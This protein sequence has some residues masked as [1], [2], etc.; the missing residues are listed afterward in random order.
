MKAKLG[1]TRRALVLGVLFI[2][3]AGAALAP[4][5]AKARNFIGVDVGPLSVGIGANE[6]DYYVAPAPAPATTYVAPAPST[7]Y[8]EPAPQTS[9]APPPATYQ[10]P[11]PT[12][13]RPTT[14]ETTTTTYFGYPN[15]STI[16]DNYQPGLVPK[17]S[18]T[19]TIYYGQ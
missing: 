14:T 12:S 18:E 10:S 8:V 6:P 1:F 2:G 17:A 13:R 5:A 15:E 16:Y 11:A 3:T 7:T 9:V 19:Q 4:S